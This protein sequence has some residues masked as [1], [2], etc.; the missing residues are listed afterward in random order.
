LNNSIRHDLLATKNLVF[1]YY[2]GPIF[3]I[4]ETNSCEAVCYKLVAWDET[5]FIRLFIMADF[6]V[7]QFRSIWKEFQK[8][9]QEKTPTWIPD[10]LTQEVAV[11]LD[12]TKHKS[13]LT[14]LSAAKVYLCETENLVLGPT[15]CLNIEDENLVKIRKIV[16]TER[17]DTI[18][19][20]QGIEI[21]LAAL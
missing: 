14:L 19:E 10:G 12:E 2:D 4:F 18:P 1:S 6:D 16:T 11:L 7:K 3:G 9:E 8:L 5:Q 20:S 15:R 21:Y 13:L 17:I